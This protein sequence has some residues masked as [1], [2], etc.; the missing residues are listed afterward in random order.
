M[1]DG[2]LRAEIACE[3]I[4]MGG[5]EPDSHMVLFLLD[6]GLPFENPCFRETANGSVLLAFLGLFGELC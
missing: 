6:E 4:W 1:K 5:P 2:M 3:E